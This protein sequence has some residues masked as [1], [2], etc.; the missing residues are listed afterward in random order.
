MLDTKVADR[1]AK[2]MI[3]EG[4]IFWAGMSFLQGDTVVTNFIQLTTGSAALAG[5][6]AT[7]KSLMWLAGQFVLGLFFHRFRSQSKVMTVGGF[8][9]RPLILIMA[10][11]IF[12][13]L[14]GRVAA[15]V[16]LGMYTLFFLID[17]ML[18]L[19]WLQICNRTL[20]IARRG[21]VISIQQ[22][23]AGIVG[24][25]AGWV[26]KALLGGSLPFQ[27]QYAVIFALAGVLMMMDAVALSLIRDVPHPSTP[28]EPPVRPVKYVRRLLPMLR[29]EPQV[30]RALIARVL[31]TLTLIASPVNLLFGRDAGLTEAQLAMLVFMPILGQIVSGVM[32]AQVCRRLSY[33]VMM[34]MAE[35][36]GALTALSNIAC[37]FIARAGLPVLIPLSVAMV[38]ISVNTAAGTGFYQQMIADVSEDKRS[39]ATVLGALVMAPLSFGTYLAGTIV[40]HWGYLPVYLIML[41][42]GT[43]GWI[44]VRRHIP[45]TAK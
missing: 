37:F 17:G 44:L 1:N 33:P 15:W 43:V 12:T 13:G 16:F 27:I 39:D 10:L 28:D 20:P 32:W 34:A 26:L 14:N 8:V 9:G 7:I 41:I 5:F 40:E 36:L 29:D 38:L 30:R 6:A 18:S 2:L 25:G 21:E 4:T 23:T 3:L 35:A 45:V 19:C 24:L 22:T 11:L 31:Y 42:S